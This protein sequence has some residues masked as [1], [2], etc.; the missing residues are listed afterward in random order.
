MWLSKMFTL[1]R[2]SSYRRFHEPSAAN[3]FEELVWYP[4]VHLVRNIY[5]RMIMLEAMTSLFQEW[6]ETLM[7][8]RPEPTT[9]AAQR[10]L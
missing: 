1:T 7:L 8:I 6:V 3:L 4:Q 10:P 5:L 2:L 9:S